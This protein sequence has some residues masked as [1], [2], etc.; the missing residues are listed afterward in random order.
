MTTDCFDVEVSTT[1]AAARAFDD[2][3]VLI[4]LYQ[5][6]P[7]A[8][9][10]EV[11]DLD[12][13][14]ALA[15]AVR[16]ALLALQTDKDYLDEALRSVRAGASVADKASARERAHVAAA[17]AWASDR[18]FEATALWGAI[19]QQFPRDLLALQFAHLGDFLLGQQ[20]ELRNRPLQALRAWGADDPAQHAV[21]GMA[22]FGLEE[23]GEFA[24]AEKIGRKAVE[25]EPC[26]GWAVHAVAH[27]MEMQGRS[28]DGASWLMSRADHWAPDNAFAY[29]NWWHLA[30]FFMDKND[31]DSALQLYDEKVR[32]QNSDV[33]MEMIDASALLWRLWVSGHDVGD[34]FSRL[35]DDWAAKGQQD[36]YAFNDVHAMMAFV[37]AGR[38]DDARACAAALERIG[39]KG[40]DNGSMARFVGAPVAQAFVA[41]A[42]HRYADAANLLHMV[43]GRA[44]RFGGSHAQRDVLTVTLFESLCRGGIRE[45]AEA[46]VAERLFHKP[47]SPWAHLWARRVDV[48][49]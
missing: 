5:G 36:L 41:F 15:W 43:R 10:D 6:D 29:H 33:V 42:E 16:G 47:E 40:T 4:R 19:V 48:L 26:D 11:L 2:A 30:L 32:P 14:F 24:D 34:R 1:E 23:C 8:A 44:Q 45:R 9:L 38:L 22:A 12:P 20:S 17:E 3:G 37:G 49:A 35:A 31:I 25:L 27:V 28:T 7:I 39:T 13:D 18:F 46:I 21:L